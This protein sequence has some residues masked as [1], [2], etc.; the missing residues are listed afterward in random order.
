MVNILTN[1]YIKEVINNHRSKGMIEEAMCV[2]II[3]NQLIKYNRY[4]L[5]LK[6]I[7]ISNFDINYYNSK[8]LTELKKNSQLYKEIREFNLLFRFF[9]KLSIN[10]GYIKKTESPDFE[11]TSN[12]ISYGIEVTRLYTGNDWIAEKI[13]NE[14]VAYNLTN[15][16]LK[17]Y[18]T[19]SNYQNRIKTFSNDDKIK[20][21]AI[22]DEYFEKEEI[23]QIKNK[24]FEKIRKQLDDYKKYDINYIFAEI[25]YTGYKQIDSYKDFSDEINNYISHLDISFDNTEFH[26]IL[27]NGNVFVDFDLKNRTFKYI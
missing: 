3:D 12:G 8:I 5:K 17:E 2:T 25:V 10:N 27:K 14:I 20:V 6:R 23:I 24:L 16:Q 15:K 19:K 1:D 7:N 22:K 18:I 13:H 21:K 11:F 26:L 4:N 9:K